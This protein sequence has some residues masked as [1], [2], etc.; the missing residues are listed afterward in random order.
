[1]TL[2]MLDTNVI[3]AAIRGESKIDQRLEQL[4]TSQ[5]C[6]SAVTHSELRFG[7]A[8][9]P[10]ATKLA[11]CV[12]GFLQLANTAPW[13]HLVADIH[14]QLRAQLRQVGTPIGHFDEMIAAH[15]MALGV[16]LV[17]DNVRHF[18]LVPGL[19]IENWQR[20]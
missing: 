19:A 9:K 15:A 13:Y 5:W 2:Y 12:E 17:T 3:S 7:L 8:L 1:M 11:K 4:D 14:G 18:Q 20:A 10:N 16:I 6:I